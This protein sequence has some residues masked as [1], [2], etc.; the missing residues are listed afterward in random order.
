MVALRPLGPSQARLVVEA[1]GAHAASIRRELH[2]DPAGYRRS[3]AREARRLFKAAAGEPATVTIGGPD[4]TPKSLSRDPVTVRVSLTHAGLGAMDAQRA[5]LELPTG[6][7]FDALPDARAGV[8]DED[9]VEDAW[10]RARWLSRRLP[11]DLGARDVREV[12]WVVR[13][14]EGAELGGGGRASDELTVGTPEAARYS[15]EVEPIDE[16]EVRAA[17]RFAVGRR[18]LSAQ[19][20]CALA[21]GVAARLDGPAP[22]LVIE[23]TPARLWRSGGAAAQEEALRRWRGLAREHPE[24]P[25]YTLA[26]AQALGWLGQRE[27]ALA[28]ALAAGG[29][30]AHRHEPATQALVGALRA[31]GKSSAHDGAGV[32][33]LREEDADA[34]AALQLAW[35]ARTVRAWVGPATA[36][37][38]PKRAT[39]AP[40]SPAHASTGRSARGDTAEPTT[41]AQQRCAAILYAAA[42]ARGDWPQV[43]ALVAEL[44]RAEGWGPKL[45]ARQVW[46]DV[47]RG[48]RPV[49]PAAVGDA[50]AARGSPWPQR[51]AA[52]LAWAA[53]G[54]AV[55]PL[56]LIQGLGS[57]RSSAT[58]WGP[59][60]RLIRGRVAQNLGLWSSARAAYGAIPAPPTPR[61]DGPYAVAQRWLAARP[62]ERTG[63]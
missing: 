18:P 5:R 24:E 29:A 11:V 51:L 12:Q 45:A 7:V 32:T 44:R 52:A 40:A 63:P 36:P 41:W 25:A 57:P 2:E 8:R 34:G 15:L 10:Q 19:A 20:A 21:K 30:A 17:A 26:F 31:K 1:W 61:H 56:R 16:R 49:E 46:V 28:L 50:R 43:D 53:R 42:A 58:P 48:A 23:M 3:W 6:S 9:P 60:V 14:P 55:R 35:L 54:E 22:G 33:A 59:A 13:W 62:D 4:G 37:D 38:E 27:E 39:G 47:A